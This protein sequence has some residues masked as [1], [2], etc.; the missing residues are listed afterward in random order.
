MFVIFLAALF[1]AQAT[2]P[3]S[4]Q[5]VPR[6]SMTSMCHTETKNDP[7]VE[8]EGRALVQLRKDWST[9]P[10]S[11]R[12]PCIQEVSVGGP[13]SYTELLVCMQM[14]EWRKAQEP[15]TTGATTA[16]AKPA[17]AKAKGQTGQPFISKAIEGNLAEV[18]LG[19]LAQQKGASDGVRTFGQQLVTDHTA[20]NQK[21]TAVAGQMSVTPPSEPNKQQKA[22]YDRMAKLSGDAFDRQFVKHMVDDHKKDVAEYQKAAKRKNDPAA[23]YASETLPTLQQHLQTAQSLAKDAGKKR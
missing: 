9:F 22:V 4:A 10:A 21:A 2:T 6:F 20:A 12:Q 17:P 7:C 19:Q 1:L 16:T 14:A 23:G 18:Q 13:P 15:E 8:S 3:A 5:D 11:A